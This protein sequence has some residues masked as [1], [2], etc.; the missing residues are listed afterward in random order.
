MFGA[1][2]ASMVES[3]GHYYTCARLSGA[4]IPTPGIICRGLAAEGLGVM[5]AGLFGRGSGSTSSSGNI[6]ILAITGVG[7]RAVIQLA[8]II[9]IIVGMMGKLMATLASLLPAIVGGVFCV[10][11]GNLVAV[12]LR[13]LEFVSIDNSQHH[14]HH[15][16]QQQQ[17]RSPSSNNKKEEL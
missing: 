9:L 15:H 13:N 5:M 8:A 11:V 16:H 12:G 10:V 4:P 3:V 1:V 2:F 17:I 7:S 6:A 14:H